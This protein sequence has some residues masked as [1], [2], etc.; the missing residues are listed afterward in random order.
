MHRLNPYESPKELSS[1]TEVLSDDNTGETVVEVL[2]LLI[3]I[4]AAV[5]MLFQIVFFLVN[6]LFQLVISKTI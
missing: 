1:N 3:I 4:A 2:I 6:T 5:V